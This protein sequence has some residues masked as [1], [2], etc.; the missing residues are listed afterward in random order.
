MKVPVL[1]HGNILLTS[2]QDDMTDRDGLQLQSDLL[3]MIQ[4]VG[5]AGV[6]MDVTGLDAVDSYQAKMIS[7]TASMAALL[8]SE[9][10]LSGVQPKVAMALVELGDVMAGVRT[11]LN[12]QQGFELLQVQAVDADDTDD[13]AD[14]TANDDDEPAQ[15]M[16]DQASRGGEADSL[17]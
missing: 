10:V 15:V 5:A 12:A 13:E 17:T 8:G 1:R 6:L 4:E 14:E 11:V 9:V 2:F 16:L 7:D 3:E